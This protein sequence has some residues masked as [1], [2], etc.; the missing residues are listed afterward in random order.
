M[1]FQ[2]PIPAKIDISSVSS[3]LTTTFP[4]LQALKECLCTEVLRLQECYG[5][6]L[7][8]VG[9]ESAEDAKYAVAIKT[10]S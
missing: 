1:R 4:T 2:A 3:T 10:F 8:E 6:L 9:E 5:K 7:S